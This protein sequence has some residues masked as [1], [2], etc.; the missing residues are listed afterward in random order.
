LKQKLSQYSNKEDETKR[1]LEGT[2]V[3]SLNC[4]ILKKL[5]SHLILRLFF[6]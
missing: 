1:R 4:S 5:I 6:V 2:S 3:W